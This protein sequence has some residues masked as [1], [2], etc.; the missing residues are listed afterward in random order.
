MITTSTLTT[1]AMAINATT[2]ITTGLISTISTNTSSVGNIFEEQNEISSVWL[3]FVQGTTS[4]SI[5]TTVTDLDVLTAIE[6]VERCKQS[7]AIMSA[8][9]MLAMLPIHV[10]CMFALF[11]K[12]EKMFNPNRLAVKARQRK[13][14]HIRTIRQVWWRCFDHDSF[15]NLLLKII[16][17]LVT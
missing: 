1:I 4:G 10:T 16:Q 11:T 15:F 7:V 13:M 14:I 12:L 8:V 5:G 9:S 3:I 2:V 6:F 17:F